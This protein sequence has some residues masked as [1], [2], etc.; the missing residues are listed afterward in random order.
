LGSRT[1]TKLYGDETIFEG[2]AQDL[3]DVAA[4]LRPFIQQAHP[5]VHQRHLLGPRDLAAADL[6]H[7]RDGVMGGA[8]RA[9]SDQGCTVAG[10][11]GDAA[12][13]SVAMAS[14]KVMAARMGGSG[15]PHPGDNPT[16]SHAWDI[17]RPPPRSLI[18][19]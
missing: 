4:E 6:P 1:P 3:Q 18:D 17:S 14:A 19:S 11:A 9:G 13:A 8:T 16:L 2:L 15:D 7:I 5:M 12:G 10:E